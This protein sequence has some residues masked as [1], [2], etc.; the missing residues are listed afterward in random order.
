MVNQRKLGLEGAHFLVGKTVKLGLLEG[1]GAPAAGKLL[2]SAP[3]FFYVKVE[4]TFGF[5]HFCVLM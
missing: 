2:F 5:L 1:Y 4:N 3:N